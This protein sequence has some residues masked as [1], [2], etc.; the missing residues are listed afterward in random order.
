MVKVEVTRRSRYLKPERL[1]RRRETRAD[2]RRSEEKDE[3][4]RER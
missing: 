2:P 1:R 4:V 3:E